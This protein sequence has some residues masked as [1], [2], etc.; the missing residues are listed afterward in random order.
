MPCSS[1][2]A[3]TIDL[4]T[5]LASNSRT[6]TAAS[7]VSPHTV[8]APASR[9]RR[10]RQRAGRTGRVPHRTGGRTT[11]P[12]WPPTSG[13]VRGRLVCRRAAVGSGHRVARAARRA[14]TIGPAPRRARSPTEFRP[15]PRRSWRSHLDRPSKRAATHRLPGRD[16][17][18][19]PRRRVSPMTRLA[20][21]A[22]QARPRV[23]DSSQALSWWNI[24]RRCGRQG[25]SRRR[26]GVR[27]CR[28]SA[29]AVGHRAS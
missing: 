22:R 20:R 18:T 27:S 12:R 14:S 28:G 1:W 21:R 5:R 17:R 8:S 19:A 26:E 24:W 23:H 13:A 10:R 29:A 7:G 6:S 15:T 3:T 11:T 16:H 9:S 25:R 2:W 4:S